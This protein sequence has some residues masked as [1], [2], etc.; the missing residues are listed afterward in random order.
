MAR[1]WMWAAAG[2]AVVAGWT[3]IQAHRGG[4]IGARAAG[5]VTATAAQQ[6][7]PPWAGQPGHLPVT[8]A[9]GPPPSPALTS[10]AIDDL[11]AGVFGAA[12]IVP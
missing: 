5:D 4:A 7:A 8:R 12:W 1:P 10:S 11:Q 9:W 6:A 2:A 3:V